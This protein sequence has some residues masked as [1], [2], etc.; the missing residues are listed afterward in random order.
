[1]DLFILINRS[2]LSLLFLLDHTLLGVNID[3]FIKD[4]IKEIKTGFFLFIFLGVRILAICIKIKVRCFLR[5]HF[6]VGVICFIVIWP[7]IELHVMGDLLFS[8]FFVFWLDILDFF[9]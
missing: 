1:M 3:T 5:P 9:V 8:W 6:T 7:N 2:L 4:S